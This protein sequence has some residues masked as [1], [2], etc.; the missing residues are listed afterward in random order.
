MAHENVHVHVQNIV[1]APV[2]VTVTETTQTPVAITVTNPA[3]LSV[4]VTITE[5]TPTPIP[6]TITEPTQTPVF[7]TVTGAGAFV[8][9]IP[10]SAT[11]ATELNIAN[12]I[13]SRDGSGNFA[14]GIIT[15]TLSGNAST[16]TTLANP[17]TING[18]SFNGSANITVPAAAGTLTGSTLATN[19]VT[20]S[21]T[22]VGGLVTGSA[23]STAGW[24]PALRATQSILLL[25]TGSTSPN[26]NRWVIGNAT[27][28]HLYIGRNTASDG[29]LAADYRL[30]MDYN[31]ASNFYNGL[32]VQTGST[33][34]IG[35]ALNVFQNG[36]TI[37]SAGTNSY[38]G[39][40]DSGINNRVGYFQ[41]LQGTTSP[42]VPNEFRIVVGDLGSGGT[43]SKGRVYVGCDDFRVSNNTLGADRF[44]VFP[45]YTAIPVAGSTTSAGLGVLRIS[46]DGT[47]T[48]ISINSSSAAGGNDFFM[49]FYDVTNGSTSVGS[50]F[51]PAST[52][53]TTYQTNSDYRLKRDDIPLA[54]SLERVMALR[55]ISYR[56]ARFADSPLEEGFFAHEVQ[57]IVPC[58]VFGEKDAEDENGNIVAQQIELSRLVPVLVGAVKELAE[59]VSA[60]EDRRDR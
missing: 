53:T 3:P 29:S 49:A 1:P 11:T 55:P 27:D 14:A 50:I 4:P 32:S 6:I 13:V 8:S 46:S 21:L 28:G 43:L 40:W 7:V 20:S 34:L 39:F 30:R 48:G 22:S 59:R 19:V 57:E 18:V 47:R 25:P 60:L 31:G 16:A 23:W 42:V 54:G 17:R 37:R 58:A 45:E 9:G 33:N 35:G 10:N 36:E 38:I 52:S 44:T 56:W 15:A 2:P 51:S 24:T 26:N 5:T 12:A 41:G